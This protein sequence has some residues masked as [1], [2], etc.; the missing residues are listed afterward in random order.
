MNKTTDRSGFLKYLWT[1][2]VYSSLF[3]SLIFMPISYGITETMKLD[4]KSQ[5]IVMAIVATC[6]LTL[7]GLALF[8]ERQR[9]KM[10][11]NYLRANIGEQ[12]SL[13]DLEGQCFHFVPKIGIVGAA[14]VGKTTLIENLVGEENTKY[15][16]YDRS[17]YIYLLDSRADR[18]AILLDG[19]GQSRAQQTD[20]AKNSEILIILFDHND[21]DQ[22]SKVSDDRLKEHRDFLTVLIDRLRTSRHHPRQVLFLLNKQD[23]WSNAYEYEIDK[24][25]SFLN[26]EKGKYIKFARSSKGVESMEFSNNR[27][28]FLTRMK[29]KLTK[30]TS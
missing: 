4:L 13:E 21:S 23:L 29:K 11:L 3:A 27:T 25:R 9:K 1:H 8:K 15:V 10:C 16:T 14:S 6:L 28:S 17:G 18:F 30:G 2:P 22:H 19:Q 7:I 24:L 20:I 5:V 26:D 12:L